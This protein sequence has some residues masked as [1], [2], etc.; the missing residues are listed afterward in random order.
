[1]SGI[2]GGLMPIRVNSLLGVGDTASEGPQVGTQVEEKD[3]FGY[4]LTRVAF[5]EGDMQIQ[6]MEMVFAA[7]PEWAS[8]MLMGKDAVQGLKSIA[9]MQGG[10]GY[11]LFA[12]ANK[13]VVQ[14]NEELLHEL[15][16]VS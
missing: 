10:Q 14:G 7:Y 1:M 16:K 11:R 4:T 8:K 2:P 5:P 13:E 12:Y 3:N 15:Q 6:T 9:G